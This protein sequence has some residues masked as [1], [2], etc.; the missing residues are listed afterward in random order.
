M[1]QYQ[2]LPIKG[3]GSAHHTRKDRLINGAAQN[4]RGQ[5]PCL[6]EL[7]THRQLGAAQHTVQC[8]TVER[9]LPTRSPLDKGVACVHVHQLHHAALR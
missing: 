8:T 6:S 1:S 2:K 3:G 9:L 4:G 7:Q 5:T